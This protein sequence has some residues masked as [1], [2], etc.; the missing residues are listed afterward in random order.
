MKRLAKAA[1]FCAAAAAGGCGVNFHQ[2]VGMS[3]GDWKQASWQA[4]GGQ[5]EL[6][7]TNGNTSVYRL[8]LSGNDRALYTF[9][10][11]RLAEISQGFGKRPSNV[12]VRVEN[13]D[14]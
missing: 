5:P 7:A 13:R 9:V 6:V 12:K 14:R 2:R 1:L 3:F 10:D 11:G 4:L 8:P